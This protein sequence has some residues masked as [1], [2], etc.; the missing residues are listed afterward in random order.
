[1][2]LKSEQEFILDAIRLLL[3]RGK[4]QRQIAETMKLSLGK[5]NELVNI[6]K[7]Q[8]KVNITKYINEEL[9]I[10]FES[11]LSG[12]NQIIDQ[13]WTSIDNCHNDKDKYPAFSLL[14]QCYEM[15]LN[16]L[17]SAE[18][19]SF[20]VKFVDKHLEQQQQE[21]RAKSS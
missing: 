5:T 14:M 11:T 9:P 21:Q 17:S 8:A 6:I 13:T 16:L 2:T 18:P 4:T 20:A 3:G 15:R 12:I 1:M 10:S 19:L 7:S